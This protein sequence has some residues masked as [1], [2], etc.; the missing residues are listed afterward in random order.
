MVFFPLEYCPVFPRKSPTNII[1]NLHKLALVYTYTRGI[2]LTLSRSRK[3]ITR[4]DWIAIKALNGLVV[5]HGNSLGDAVTV[6]TFSEVWARRFVALNALE[7]NFVTCG[8]EGFSG[9]CPD[10]CAARWVHTRFAADG[11]WRG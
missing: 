6:A 7:I 10:F 2:V 3:V 1:H 8:A 5:V 4:E 11:G 9:D